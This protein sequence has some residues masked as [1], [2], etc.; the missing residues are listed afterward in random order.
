LVA[1]GEFFHH[2]VISRDGSRIGVGQVVDRTRPL[3]ALPAAG[4][5]AEKICEGCGMTYQWARDNRRAL[6]M[7]PQP[8]NRTSVGL[9]DTMSGKRTVLAEHPSQ[10]LWQGQF[11]PDERW[12]SFHAIT[13]PAQSRVF[14]I[15][16]RESATPPEQWVPITDGRSSVDKPRWSPDGNLMYYTSDE[17][18]FRCIWARRLNP[19]TKQPTGEPFGVFHSH[20]ARRSLARVPLYPLEINVAR[21]RLVFNLA[22]RTGNIWMTTVK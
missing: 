5:A 11:S 19:A 9:L 20:S 7:L 2:P 8:G 15:P 12:V 10:N 1:A 3:F 22:E 13:G 6:V 18:G 21:D 4:G 14:V 16:F 17:D